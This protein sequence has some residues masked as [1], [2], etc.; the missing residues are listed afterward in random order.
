M[1]TGVLGGGAGLGAAGAWSR[2]PACPS[3]GHE[4]HPHTSGGSGGGGPGEAD[5]SPRE[6]TRCRWL[7]GL[8][9][10]HESQTAFARREECKADPR[11]KTFESMMTARRGLRRRGS[12]L[13]GE[14]TSTASVTLPRVTPTGNRPEPGSGAREAALGGFGDPGDEATGWGSRVHDRPPGGDT[15]RKRH[16]G[17]RPSPG[18]APSRAAAVCA[19][20]GPRSCRMEVAGFRGSEQGP[21]RPSPGRARALRSSLTATG[22]PGT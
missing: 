18:G 3:P 13:F 14:E 11:F 22:H 4:S 10:P 6:V 16:W 8:R 15:S 19:R 20:T 12:S 2:G 5:L 9:L 1:G 7:T 21:R 17:C